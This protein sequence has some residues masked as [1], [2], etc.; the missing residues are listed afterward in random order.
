MPQQIITNFSGGMVSPDLSGRLDLDLFFASSRWLQNFIPRIQGPMNYRG[1]TRHNG[2]T[3]Q[4]L[5][6]RVETFR[7]NDEQAYILEFTNQKLRIYEDASLTLNTSGKTI[8]GATQ[9]DPVVIT[10]TAHGF[11]AGD[12]VYITGVGG[13]SEING[14]FFRVANPNTNDFELVDQFGNAVDGTAFGA[15]TSGGTATLVYEL[16]S[17]FTTAQLFE[18]QFAQSGNVMYLVHRSHAPYKLTRVSST[19][20]TLATYSRTSDPFGSSNNYPGCVTFFEGRSVFASTNNNPDTVWASRAP[21]STGAARYDDFTTGSNADDAI[22]IP[23][24]PSRGSI[25]YINWI[26][27]TTDFIALGTVSG[28]S[29][30]DGGGDDSPITPSDHRVRPIDPYGVQAIMPIAN[31]SSLFYMQKGNRILRSFEYELLVDSYKSFNQSFVAPRLTQGGIRQLAFQRGQPDVI[32][33]VRNDGVLLGKTIKSKDDVTGWHPHYLGK[34]GKVLSI[35][36]LPQQAGYDQLWL[37][38]ERTINGTTVRYHEHLTEPFEGLDFE[39]YFTEDEAADTVAWQNEIFEAQRLTTYLDSHLIYNGF[40]AGGGA[41]SITPGAT[42]GAS[43]TFTASGPIF[44]SAD[45]GRQIWKKYADRAGGGVA[46][47]IQF[48]SATEVVCKILVAFDSTA[49]IPGGSWSFTTNQVT[50]LHHLEGETIQVFTDGRTHPDVVVTAGVAALDRQAGVV[51]GGLKYSGIY[52]SQRLVVAGAGGPAVTEQRNVVDVDIQFTESIGVKYG[53]SLYRLSE[54]PASQI[55]QLT[56]RPPLPFT[57]TRGG[58]YEDE[59]SA[60]KTLFILQD[61]PYP[62]QVNSLVMSLDVGEE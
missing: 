26:A 58:F 41:I 21:L 22:I 56:D 6:A 20:W 59:W 62:C 23:V 44:T 45:V 14:R 38:V 29:R 8:S 37:V 18:F 52:R 33:A 34:S 57:G 7:F 11:S 19:S 17:P 36:V 51:L 61:K 5:D 55:G 24:A 60:D 10:A 2:V 49:A 1:G 32:W 4:N 28:V 47:I 13:M 9:A 53:T 42:S 16:T 39:K 30:L 43:V 15:Y 48:N 27:G 46:E 3:R 25:E 50:G 54:I 35:A 40:N 12:E 31:G